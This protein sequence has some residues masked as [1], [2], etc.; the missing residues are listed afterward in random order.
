[1]TLSPSQADATPVAADVD[2][3][4]A[5][6]DRIKVLQSQLK[7][8][9]D[10][11]KDALGEAIEGVDA[12]GRVLVRYPHRNRSDLDRKKVKAILSDEEY[13]QCVRETGYRVLLYP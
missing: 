6:R 10:T 4:A 12:S 2:A 3:A 7:V 8:H 1:M 11:I 9:E 13:S 5:L